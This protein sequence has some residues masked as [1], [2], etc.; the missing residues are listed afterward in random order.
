MRPSGLKLFAD[1]FFRVMRQAHGAIAAKLI[2]KKI[3]A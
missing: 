1:F 3:V 2:V